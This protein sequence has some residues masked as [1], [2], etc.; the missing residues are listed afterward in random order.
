M[1]T[2]NPEP[3]SDPTLGFAEFSKPSKFKWGVM[4]YAEAHRTVERHEDPKG[5]A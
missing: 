2:K 1:I 3:W 5:K 4:G